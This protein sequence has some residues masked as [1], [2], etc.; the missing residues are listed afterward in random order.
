MSA[1]TR[2][3]NLGPPSSRRADDG[4]RERREF[5]SLMA[6]R[7]G[8]AP[9]RKPFYVDGGTDLVSLCRLLAEQDKTGA[10]VRDGDWD[11]CA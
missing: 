9:L 3:E 4:D 2:L 10:L 6:A 5:L 7:V 11:C 8:D 1:D